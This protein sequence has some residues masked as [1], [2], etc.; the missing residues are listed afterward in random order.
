MV[1]WTVS[2][3]EYIQSKL[4]NIEGVLRKYGLSLRKGTKS[5]L[6]GSYKPECDFTPECDT[7]NARLYDPLIGILRWLVELGRIDI[8]CEVSMM[9]FHTAM[10]QE[11]HLNHML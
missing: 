1:A 4:K 9:S 8:N 5:P 11:G 10:P 7:S 2:T 3:S 6:H